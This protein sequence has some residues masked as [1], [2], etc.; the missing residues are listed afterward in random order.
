MPTKKDTRAAAT[1]LRD[2][3]N[4]AAAAPKPAARPVVQLE[5]PDDDDDDLIAAI[6]VDAAVQRRRTNNPPASTAPA[7]P[8][9][10]PAPPSTAPAPPPPAQHSRRSAPPA[11][12]SARAPALDGSGLDW[13][14]EH[15]C[16]MRHCVRLMDHMDALKELLDMYEY[17]LSE[18][19]AQVGL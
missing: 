10:A 5:I 4:G 3:T 14:C 7:P 6:D 13:R 8:P 19:D 18:D 12:S 9:P 1:A 11:S 17:Q 2:R 15:G 16:A